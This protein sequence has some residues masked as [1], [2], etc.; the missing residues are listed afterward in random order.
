M[1]NS[2]LGENHAYVRGQP[3]SGGRAVQQPV[4]GRCEGDGFDPRALRYGALRG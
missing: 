3:G 1:C 2:T 4:L